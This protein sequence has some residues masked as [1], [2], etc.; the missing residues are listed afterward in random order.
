[1]IATSFIVDE[2]VHLVLFLLACPLSVFTLSI[3][4]K[5][6]GKKRF[7][8]LGIT[9]L[10]FMALGLVHGLPHALETVLTTLG[11]IILALAHLGNYQTNRH[12]KL[13]ELSYE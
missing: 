13:S 6:H 10:G 12:S 4:A 3:G 9:G 5:L 7:F 11:V 2:W 1:M 8:G